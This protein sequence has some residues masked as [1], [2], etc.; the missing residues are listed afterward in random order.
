[1]FSAFNLLVGIIFLLNRIFL[2]ADLVLKKICNYSY[3]PR[4]SRARAGVGSNLF[5]AFSLEKGK[6]VSAFLNGLPKTHRFPFQPTYVH[7]SY[8][9]CGLMFLLAKRIQVLIEKA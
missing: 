4:E 8:Y 2:W 1:M 7:V 9:G 5:Y 6:S 3:L